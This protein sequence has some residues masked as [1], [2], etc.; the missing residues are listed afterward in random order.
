MFQ[1]QNLDEKVW[2]MDEKVL[3]MDQ[4]VWLMDEKV[5]LIF[6]CSDVL[7]LPPLV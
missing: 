5:W 7:Y 6:T 2:L 1:A 3:F 4:K